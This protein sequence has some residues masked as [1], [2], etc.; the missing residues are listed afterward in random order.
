MGHRV[1]KEDQAV[2]EEM[3]SAG[4]KVREIADRLGIT[5]R[6]VFKWRR[7]LGLPRRRI[8]GARATLPQIERYILERGIAP[9]GDVSEHFGYSHKSRGMVFGK[10]KKSEKVRELRLELRLSTGGTKF[11]SG[12]LLNG[13]MRQR[14]LYHLDN[15]K[16]L[17]DFLVHVIETSIPKLTVGHRRALARHLR[18]SLKIPDSVAEAVIKRMSA[19]AAE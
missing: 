6:A 8:F 3:W 5:P 13:F 16:P 9:Y 7:R 11:R 18:S 15:L 10:I 2:L 14:Y 4:K 12:E 17:E 19:R 1:T